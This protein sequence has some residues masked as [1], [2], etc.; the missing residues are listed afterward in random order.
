MSHIVTVVNKNGTVDEQ[1]IENLGLW[2]VG[3]GG[4]RG[5]FLGE[6]R[7]FLIV[8]ETIAGWLLSCGEVIIQSLLSLL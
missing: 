6:D 1:V 7:V 4:G 5:K 2:W 3:W 8:S